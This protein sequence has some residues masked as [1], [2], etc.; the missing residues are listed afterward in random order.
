MNCHFYLI[1]KLVAET[2]TWA[3]ALQCIYERVYDDI[4]LRALRRDEL[5]SSSQ[6]D[7]LNRTGINH[8]ELWQADA[9][10]AADQSVNHSVWTRHTKTSVNPG[11][12]LSSSTNKRD[13]KNRTQSNMRQRPDVASHASLMWDDLKWC[14]VKGDEV[15]Q[16]KTVMWGQR[17]V[18]RHDAV[19][20]QTGV[21]R[22]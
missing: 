18:R 3:E 10:T 4:R 16:H 22:H 6:C 5:L 7:S 14:K 20:G 12:C 1:R 15:K 9:L 8:S 19:W 2:Q 21:M 11:V 13:D 17:A